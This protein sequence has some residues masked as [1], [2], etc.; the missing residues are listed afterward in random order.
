M[1][2]RAKAPKYPNRHPTRRKDEKA[3]KVTL[4]IFQRKLD[5]RSTGWTAHSCAQEL[6]VTD[7]WDDTGPE[8]LLLCSVSP[9][10]R[11]STPCHRSVGEKEKTPLPAGA[12]SAWARW[13]PPH[14][15]V[16][17]HL[18]CPCVRGAELSGEAL[19]PTTLNEDTWVRGAASCLS[20]LIF[21]TRVWSSRLC[22]CSVSEVFWV[23]SQRGDVCV[24][25]KTS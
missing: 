3:P 11:S 15:R 10:S 2:N 21:L 9:M 14:P 7:A 16:R 18:N 1:T 12:L 25:R 17:G 19:A 5:T 20:S 4:S 8:S 24:T 13:V 23:S 22:Q 6:Y